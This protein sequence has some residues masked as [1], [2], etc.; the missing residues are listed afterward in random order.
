MK[1][2]NQYPAIFI[3]RPNRFI[4]TVDIE[5]TIE[6]V[7]VKNTGRCRE[8]LIPGVKVM[9]EKSNNPDRKTKYD[10]VMVYKENLGWVNIDSQMPNALVREWLESEPEEFSG[11]TL[12]KPEYTYGDSRVDFYLERGDEKILIEVKGVTLEIDGIGYFPDAPTE[13]GVKHIRELIKARREG[14]EAYIAFVIQMNGIKEVRANMNTHREFGVAL[15][16]AQ[17]AGVKVLMLECNV[18]E[19]EIKIHCGGTIHEN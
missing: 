6:T 2:T 8:L 1:Y 9:L 18:S 15:E 12:I 7:H 17:K 14:Y 16:E 11:L 5:G 3:S 10:L 4:A 13:R 19:N